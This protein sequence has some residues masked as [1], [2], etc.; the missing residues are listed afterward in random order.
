MTEAE[1]LEMLEL[2]EEEAMAGQ[3]PQAS[4][5]APGED[6]VTSAGR[7]LS[8]GL[9]FGFA[10]E[11][12]GALQSKFGKAAPWLFT[13]IGDLAEGKTREPVE[14]GYSE[15]RDEYRQLNEQ[16]KAANPNAHMGGEFGGSMIAAKSIPGGKTLGS[17]IASGGA[18]GLLSGLGTGTSDV[19][20]GDVGGGALESGLG[21]VIG[22]AGG[23]A[24]YGLGK[25]IQSVANS[26]P[27]K[28]VQGKISKAVGDAGEQAAAKV[29]DI[30]ASAQ[31]RYR[32]KVQEASRD[33]EVL[34]R[35]AAEGV[36]EVADKAR[37]FLKTP[38]AD[39]LRNMVLEN[40]LI[41]A[42]ERIGD[43]GGLKKQFSDLV[44][45]RERAVMDAQGQILAD[46]LKKQVAP[47]MRKQVM[48]RVAV[49]AIGSAVG[50]GLGALFGGE[51]NRGTGAAV[52][53]GLGSAFAGAAGAALGGRPS[54]AFENMVK[55]P[56]VRNAWW[57]GVKRML[58]DAPQALG[59]FGPQL[60]RALQRGEQAFAVEAFVLNEQM[61]KFREMISR[62]MSGEEEVASADR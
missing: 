8:Q 25:A 15:A 24:G 55:H 45:D 38:E 39:A 43:V 27:A 35:E 31:G 54:T 53:M 62:L 57:N 23:A 59:E 47:R 52:G 21:G 49:P 32:G 56:G 30:I 14:Q 42:P 37:A 34:L 46:P 44:A 58:V 4:A 12:L 13:S 28:W 50:A 40:K 19:A 60:S 33:L 20:N 2:E 29:D 5:E 3:A 7:G 22:M 36:G 26:S 17:A 6:A 9:S 51:D 10:D 48:D 18:M 61:P 16:S 1:E 11:A 41:S